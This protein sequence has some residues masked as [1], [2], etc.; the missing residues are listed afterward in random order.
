MPRLW[1]HVG[2]FLASCVTT[3]LAG[4]AYFAATLM[5]ILLAH[6]LGHYIVG[7]RAGA[8]MSPPYF[9]PTPYL[10]YGTLGAV[11]GMRTPIADRNV[12]FDV[13]AAGPV[14]GLVVALPL[15]VIGLLL[16]PVGPPAPGNVMEGNSILYALIKLAVFGRW[17]PGGG[18]DVNLHPMGFAAW[19]G[20]LITAINLMPVGQLDGGHIARAILGDRHEQ[21]SARLN[22]ALPLIGLAVGGVMVATALDAGKDTWGAVAYG[23][24]GLAPWCVWALLLWGMRHQAGAYHPPVDAAPLDP[25]RRRRAIAM[26]VL[27][28]LIVTP[29]PIRPVL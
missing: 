10:G 9:L 2:L 20:L 3:Y 5:S 26:L 27:F 18:V 23:G 21:L 28:C 19:V 17:L 4:G 16:S 6:E 25:G 24:H 12:L 1:L 29:V 8:D 22:V 14:A 15:L 11:I 7:R 13:G